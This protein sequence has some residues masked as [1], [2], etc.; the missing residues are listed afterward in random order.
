LEPL[1]ASAARAPKLFLAIFL[2]SPFS[3]VGLNHAAGIRLHRL[4]VREL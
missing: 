1:T 3:I 4:R 2:I